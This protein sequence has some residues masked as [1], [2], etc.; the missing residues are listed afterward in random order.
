[1]RTPAPTKAEQACVHSNY[2]VIELIA[3]RRTIVVGD[4]MLA[5]IV[6]AHYTQPPK[7]LTTETGR[8]TG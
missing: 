3:A 4:S 8:Q 1:L 7:G 6:A 2:S 5:R